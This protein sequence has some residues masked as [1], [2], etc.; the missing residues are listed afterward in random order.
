MLR[1]DYLYQ[2]IICKPGLLYDTCSEVKIDAAALVYQCAEGYAFASNR[3]EFT[4]TV[5]C[6]INGDGSAAEYTWPDGSSWGTC[7]NEVRSH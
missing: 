7:V 4:T 3:N 5:P 6:V 2:K 1:L